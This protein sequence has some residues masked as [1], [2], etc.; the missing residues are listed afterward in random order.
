M[1][2]LLTGKEWLMGM[3]RY[4]LPSFPMVARHG[5]GFS[6]CLLCCFLQKVLL[7]ICFLRKIVEQYL[8]DSTYM[9]RDLG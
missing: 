2:Q 7:C 6:V 9:A 1:A 3:Q 5:L 4:D 8:V